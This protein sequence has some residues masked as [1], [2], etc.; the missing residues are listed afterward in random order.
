MAYFNHYDAP[1][2]T[3]LLVSDGSNLTGLY[4]NREIPEETELPVFTQTKQWL[5]AYFRGE[6]L[7]VDIPI[8]LIG[9]PFQ[10]RVWELL[11]E[12]PFGQTRTYGQIAEQIARE[13]GKTK[14]SS[15]AVGQ[16]VG[17]NPVSILIPCHRVVGANGKLTGYAGG[18]ENKKWLLGH[19]GWQI[20][21]EKIVREMER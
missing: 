11:K 5:D 9:T 10:V 14:M 17:K 6:N 21:N 18:L 19:E 3:L 20:Q 7:V 1:I 13:T 2:G 8:D 16:A 15:Q 12:I 4:M